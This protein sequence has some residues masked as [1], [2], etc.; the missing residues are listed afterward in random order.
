MTDTQDMP[1]AIYAGYFIQ[2][3]KDIG[4]K[5]W[6]HSPD[7]IKTLKDNHDCFVGKDY[8]RKDIADE[9]VRAEREWSDA[10]ALHLS[11]MLEDGDE[12]DIGAAKKDLSAYQKLALN[13]YREARK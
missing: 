2:G 4:D 7:L 9:R 5:D 13:R 10:L 12:E 11:N 8:Q 6:V 3:Q 1:E